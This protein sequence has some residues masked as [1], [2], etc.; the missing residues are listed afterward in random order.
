MESM[1]QLLD[2][3]LTLGSYEYS[4]TVAGHRVIFNLVNVGATASALVALPIKVKDDEKAA[5]MAVAM[6]SANN[7][8]FN[9]GDIND[10]LL[11]K[12]RFLRELKRPLFDLFWDE[13]VAAEARQLHIFEETHAKGKKS[14]PIQDSEDSGDS[15]NSP[16]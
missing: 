6:V 9:S 4:F 5:R 2:P 13:Y 10:P 11:E 8:T 3:I 12:F 7:Y 16:E 14:F 15:S 1:K